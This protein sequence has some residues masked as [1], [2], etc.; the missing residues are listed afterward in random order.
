MPLTVILATAGY[1]HKLRYWDANTGNCT[2]TT[3]F[4]ESQVN[5]LEIAPNKYYLAAA[6]NPNIHLFD[7][8]SASDTPVITFEGHSGNVTDIGFQ[9][10]TQ[11]L[12]SCSEDGT[13][14]I[15]DLRAPEAQRTYDCQCAIH[16]SVLHPDQATILSADQNG[17]VKTWDLLAGD[18][19]RNELSVSSDAPIRSLAIVNIHFFHILFLRSHYNITFNY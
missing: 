5:A 10:D 14:K 18:K 7:V 15:W 6:G 11:W 9:Q 19:F 3:K 12:Y 13:I 17:F 1:D 8:N 16:S 2:K 4:E